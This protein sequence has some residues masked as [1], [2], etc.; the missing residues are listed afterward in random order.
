MTISAAERADLDS[1]AELDQRPTAVQR[2]GRT[3]GQA[4]SAYVVLDL[5]EAFDWLGS[6]D[7]SPDQWKAVTAAAVAVL[8]AVQNLGPKVPGLVAGAWRAMRHS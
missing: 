1:L 8:A 5:A 3:A 6:A 7:W 2:V 4:A